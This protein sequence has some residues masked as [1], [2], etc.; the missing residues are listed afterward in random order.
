MVPCSFVLCSLIANPIFSLIKERITRPTR[1][2]SSSLSLLVENESK[3]ERRTID[4][5][6]YFFVSFASFSLVI[7]VVGDHVQ[8]I[9][10]TLIVDEL[11]RSR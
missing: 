11:P 1:T 5:V 4:T 7:A 8:P 2:Y 9:G 10:E 6:F 3:H